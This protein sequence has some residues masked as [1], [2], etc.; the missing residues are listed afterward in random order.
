VPG[1]RLPGQ[2]EEWRASGFHVSSGGGGGTL[3]GL[4]A[5]SAA[6]SP[7]PRGSMHGQ[8]AR[9]D[10]CVRTQPLCPTVTAFDGP[11]TSD[12]QVEVGAG[13]LSLIGTTCPKRPHM[14]RRLLVRHSRSP[15]ASGR[16][17]PQSAPNRCDV[18]RPL[19]RLALPQ[20]PPRAWI[21]TPWSR[22]PL[23]AW[24]MRHWPPLRHRR[25][26][27]RVSCQAHGGVRLVL[28]LLFGLRHTASKCSFRVRTWPCVSIL[29]HS[30]KP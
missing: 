19:L 4:R 3:G 7:H 11:A 1:A 21:S 14:R 24:H 10:R 18:Q 20:P 12:A 27:G 30:H 16:R 28:E 29:P 22:R 9:A 6:D 25:A 8:S 15:R 5:E 23:K 26:C 17:W 13:M 2:R